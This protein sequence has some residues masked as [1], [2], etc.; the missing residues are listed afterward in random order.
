V[1]VFSSIAGGPQSTKTA[2]AAAPRPAV[3]YFLSI[4]I[5]LVSILKTQVQY[6]KKSG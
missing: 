3:R 1:D 5:M 6:N 2:T 4:F